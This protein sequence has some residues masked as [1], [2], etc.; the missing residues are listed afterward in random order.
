MRNG[1]ICFPVSLQDK[2]FVM[3]GACPWDDKQNKEWE[4]ANLLLVQNRFSAPLKMYTTGKSEF[5]GGNISDMHIHTVSVM[6]SEYR[7]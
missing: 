2:G 7:D 6:H 4:K 3:D 5:G 1:D